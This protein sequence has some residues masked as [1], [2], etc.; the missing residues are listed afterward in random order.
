MSTI[1]LS[2]IQACSIVDFNSD[3][4][5]QQL[6]QFLSLCQH[7]T[8]K[9]IISNHV[10]SVSIKNSRDDKHQLSTLVPSI[11]CKNI[12]YSMEVK[13]GGAH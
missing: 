13:P 6:V 4:V 1:C 11:F 5:N 10:L 2:Q 8:L 3:A 12:K 9:A 7:V